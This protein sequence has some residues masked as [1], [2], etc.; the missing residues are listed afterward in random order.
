MAFQLDFV[1]KYIS[2]FLIWM[3]FNKTCISFKYDLI[4]TIT[5]NDVFKAVTTNLRIRKTCLVQVIK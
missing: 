2:C 4:G 3:L 1:F 5:I